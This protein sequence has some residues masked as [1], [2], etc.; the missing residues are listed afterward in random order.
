MHRDHKL[1]GLKP[2]FVLE[3]VI[4]WDAELNEA[5]DERSDACATNGTRDHAR[6]WPHDDEATDQRQDKETKSAQNKAEE[7]SIPGSLLRTGEG[8]V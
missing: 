2:F 4:V 5:R 7:A 8:C 3:R 6:Q 1:T